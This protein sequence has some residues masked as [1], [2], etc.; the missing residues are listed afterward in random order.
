VECNKVRVSIIMEPRNG[1]NGKRHS[2]SAERVK[3]KQKMQG[4]K[5]RKG[6]NMIEWNGSEKWFQ[7]DISVE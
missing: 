6:G 1:G 2:R 5:S 7:W 3:L 4:M